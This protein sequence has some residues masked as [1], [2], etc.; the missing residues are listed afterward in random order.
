MGKP[1]LLIVE[2]DTDIANMLQILFN[3]QNFEV[4]LAHRG[5]EALEKTRQNLPNL[6]VLDIMLPDIDGFDVCRVLRTHTRTSHVPIIF[7][8]QKD[9]RSDKLQGLELG[10][11]DYITKPFDI[12]EL[13]L[14]VQRAITRADQQSLTDPRSGLPSGRLIEEQLRRIIRLDSWA[15]M[16][17]RIIHYEVFRDVY[18]FVAADNLL[19]FTA[20]LMGDVIDELGTQNDFIGHSGGENFVVVTTEAAVRKISDILRQRF[21]EESLAHYSFL[22]RERG[23]IEAELSDGSVVQAPLMKLAVGIVSPSKNDFSDI[24][25]ITELAAESRRQQSLN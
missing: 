14:R 2:D 11:D 8:T 3:A 18:G 13:K 21:K 25:E 24:R 4:D 22:D 17:L 6:I 16:D 19:R 7:L 9:E 15:F 10:A 23:F 5:S 20:M 12:E 1:R